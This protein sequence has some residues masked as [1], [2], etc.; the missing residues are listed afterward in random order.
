MDNFLTSDQRP[1]TEPE[2][3][4]LSRVNSDKKEFGSTT[5]PGTS[6]GKVKIV[7]IRARDVVQG[8]LQLQPEMKVNFYNV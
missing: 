5:N 3:M 8:I 4:T 7:Q 6:P 2:V 1:E